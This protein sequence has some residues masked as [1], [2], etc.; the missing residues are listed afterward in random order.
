M[1]AEDKSV[2]E[3]EAQEGV[4]ETLEPPPVLLL[5][6]KPALTVREPG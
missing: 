4:A 6:Q 3:K 2:A 1:E 5:E